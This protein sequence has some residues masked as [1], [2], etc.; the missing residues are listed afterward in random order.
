[1]MRFLN[2]LFFN[3]IVFSLIQYTH[4][5]CPTSYCSNIKYFGTIV[6]YP[7]K[8]QG[9]DPKICSNYTDLRCDPQNRTNVN[10]PYSG[11]FIVDDIDY[12]TETATLSDPEDCLLKRLMMNL[13][14]SSSPFS[15]IMYENYT[16]YNCPL[17]TKLIQ[18]GFEGMACLRNDTG[19]N[20]TIASSSVNSP[21]TMITKFG[22]SEVV[23]VQ[24]PVRRNGQFDYSGF[25]SK[26]ELKWSAPDCLA[27]YQTGTLI[28]LI[29][30]SSI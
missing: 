28:N 3:F 10:L 27:C 19:N 9:Q 24:L 17:T 8:L 1:M 30:I 21:E 12:V 22:C 4:A 14:L 7:F 15:A 29:L 18:D 25:D 11:D 23:T 6:R 13:N 26:L 16:F 5:T 2:F 20:A